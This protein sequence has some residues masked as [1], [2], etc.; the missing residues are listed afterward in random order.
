MKE[1]D[2]IYLY[3][4]TA[5]KHEIKTHWY[6][7]QG[8]LAN[9]AGISGAFLSDIIK[10][11]TEPS[12]LNKKA[13]A[14]ACGYDYEEFLEY[15]RNLKEEKPISK[16]TNLPEKK[17][18]PISK[19]VKKGA[20]NVGDTSNELL[21]VLKDQIAELKQ[22]KL[23]LKQ[24]LKEQRKTSDRLYEQN[25]ELAKQLGEAN[26]ALNKTKMQQATGLESPSKPAASG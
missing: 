9:E 17:A 1:E 12:F 8:T 24:E 26:Q 15:G 20:V 6:R 7:Q 22:E 18:K 2:P 4:L 11:R 3:F 25:L 5:L 13:L 16:T 21:Q 23:E 10:K 19:S 14:Y